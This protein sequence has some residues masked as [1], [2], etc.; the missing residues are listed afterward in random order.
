MAWQDLLYYAAAVA[1]GLMGSA[2]FVRLVTNDD[3]PPSIWVR[4]TW[5]RITRDGQWS[6]LIACL[7]CFAPYVVAADM[8][9]AWLSDFHWSWWVANAWMAFSY[10]VSW[11]VFHDERGAPPEEEG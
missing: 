9:W 1:V 11:L 3:F 4:N 2:R 7:W 8:L 5:R 6:N 10:V